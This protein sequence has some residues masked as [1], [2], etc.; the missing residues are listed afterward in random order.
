MSFICV[1]F[2]G[3]SIATDVRYNTSEEVCE[4]DTAV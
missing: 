1:S 4:P 3:I 2:K